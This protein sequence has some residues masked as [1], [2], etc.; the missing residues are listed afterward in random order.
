M[1]T[2]NGRE[3]ILNP[4][5]LAKKSFFWGGGG[6]GGNSHPLANRGPKLPSYF[7]LKILAFKTPSPLWSSNDYTWCVY[8][9]SLEPTCTHI[10][11]RLVIQRISTRLSHISWD[12]SGIFCRLNVGFCQLACQKQKHSHWERSSKTFF[13][14]MGTAQGVPTGQGLYFFMNLEN[15]KDT[16]STHL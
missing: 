16:A 6:E 5:H 3:N 10:I 11:L 12:S 2:K 1:F 13:W 4:A 15:E 8:G 14:N 7:P 9:Y